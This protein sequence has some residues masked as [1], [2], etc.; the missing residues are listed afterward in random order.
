VEFA[1]FHAVPFGGV[2]ASGYGRRGGRAGFMEFSNLR[3]RVRHGRWAMSRMFD[4]PRTEKAL[5]MAR[6]LVGIKPKA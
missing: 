6:R 5:S 2:G 1:A 3:L 4:A